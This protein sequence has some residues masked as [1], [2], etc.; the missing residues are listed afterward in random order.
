MGFGMDR[1]HLISPQIG[2][3]YVRFFAM[4]LVMPMD[5]AMQKPMGQLCSSDWI[6]I[7]LYKYNQMM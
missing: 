6:R 7:K 4:K 5:Y 2:M 1:I 3:I